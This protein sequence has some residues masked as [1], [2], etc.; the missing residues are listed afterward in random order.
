MQECLT[1]VIPLQA[2]RIVAEQRFIWPGGYAMGIMT[3][4]GGCLCG[5]CVKKELKNITD[6][7]ASS[8]WKP[9]AA[10]YTD[11]DD[12]N[13]MC[14]HC[15]RPLTDGTDEGEL[16][17][18]SDKEVENSD[19]IVNEATAANRIREVSRLV[20]D[21]Q[22]E[23]ERREEQMENEVQE[24]KDRSRE[25]LKAKIEAKGGGDWYTAEEGLPRDHYRRGE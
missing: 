15:G 16:I 18:P 13:T 22:D 21:M 23:A 9:Q 4:D 19:N 7:T 12:E 8:Q 1:N 24:S 14:D 17:L 2:A 20:E 25:A 10:F 5:A 3:E 11:A 6:P